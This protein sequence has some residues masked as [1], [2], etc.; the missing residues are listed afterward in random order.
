MDRDMKKTQEEQ[1]MMQKELFEAIN[2]ALGG[3]KFF[4]NIVVH[5]GET[6]TKAGMVHNNSFSQLTNLDFGKDSFDLVKNML[7]NYKNMVDQSVAALLG[8]LP[9]PLASAPTKE[10][11]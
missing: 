10:Y 3:K 1:Q 9:P 11:Q 6:P 8:L 4:C 5:H 2:S 7:L